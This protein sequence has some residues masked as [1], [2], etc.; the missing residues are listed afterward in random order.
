MDWA[1]AQIIK[2]VLE[3]IAHFMQARMGLQRKHDVAVFKKLNA[4]AN[5]SRIDDILHHRIVTSQLRPE[6]EQLIDNLIGAFHR[7]ENR[8]L[9]A[10]VQLRA[11]ELVWEMDRLAAIVSTTFWSG[12]HGWKK[13]R[14]NLIDKPVHDAEWKELNDRIDRTWDAYGAYRMAVKERLKV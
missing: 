12:Q 14:P 8:Y 9:D 13:F 6:D 5:E 7:I 4:I 10:T 3:P 1:W 11:D 2:P